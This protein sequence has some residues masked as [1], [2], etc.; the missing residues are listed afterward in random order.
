MFDTGVLDAVVHEGMGT[1]GVHSENG[2]RECLCRAGSMGGDPR[3]LREVGPV[4]SNRWIVRRAVLFR[5]VVDSRMA[6][7]VA[8]RSLYTT[9][10]DC[11]MGERSRDECAKSLDLR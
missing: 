1:D 6:S 2:V 9:P 11:L 3:G 5:A 7:C 8:E 10:A 4:E